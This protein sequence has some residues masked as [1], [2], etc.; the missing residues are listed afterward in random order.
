MQVISLN[1]H[2][3]RK[4]LNLSLN[5]MAVLCDIVQMSQN[6]KYGHWCIKSKE[7]IAEW[8]NLSKDTVFRAINTLESKGYIE[9][10]LTGVR[11][12]RFIYDLSMAQEEIGIYI[13]SNDV[14]LISMKMREI[15]S[16][17]APTE[18]QSMTDGNSVTTPT[19]IPSQDIHRDIQEKTIYISPAKKSRKSVSC[20][21]PTLEEVKAYFDE[22]G[23]KEEIAVKAWEYYE[24]ANWEDGQG[25]KVKSWKQK[26]IGVWFK[27]EN[28]KPK[29]K[30]KIDTTPDDWEE[31]A[32]GI[33]KA[34]WASG[35]KED[36]SHLDEKELDWVWRFQRMGKMNYPYRPNQ[37]LVEYRK[38]T[39]E[40]Q[41]KQ[42]NANN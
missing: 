42:S 12:T 1:N 10:G 28:L 39:T 31:K 27:P 20:V 37:K 40:A 23:Y 30:V 3:V 6:P 17:D 18:I 15:T 13:K 21:T 36:W 38:Y 32:R 9:K 14:E 25:K 22:K 16:S 19:E 34:L 7:K 11:P 41:Q 24:A 4:A 8:L 33:Y 35:N 26:M 5:E 2:I 29:E